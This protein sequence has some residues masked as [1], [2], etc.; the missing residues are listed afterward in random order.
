ME[1]IGCMDRQYSN[2]MKLANYMFFYLPI[3]RHER[4]NYGFKYDSDSDKYIFD[5]GYICGLCGDV[6]DTWGGRGGVKNHLI[7]NHPE[8][9]DAYIIFG[10]YS[11]DHIKKVQKLAFDMLTNDM[12]LVGG[13]CKAAEE[14]D[15][16]FCLLCGKPLYKDD[17]LAHIESNHQ[18]WISAIWIVEKMK[19]Y[20]KQE[21]HRYPLKP[22]KDPQSLFCSPNLK[23]IINKEPL[24]GDEC[25]DSERDKH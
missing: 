24:S 6:V 25:R 17:C 22:W 15:W 18:N 5:D 1:E 21:R 3:E 4:K 9:A 19:K 2:A 11:P 8:W 7:E 10:G 16:Y 12:V 23:Y 13:Q 20:V 14:Y